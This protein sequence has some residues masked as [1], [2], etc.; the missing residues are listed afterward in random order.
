MGIRQMNHPE[1][2]FSSMNPERVAYFE[3]KLDGVTLDDIK[4]NDLDKHGISNRHGFLLDLMRGG[5]APIAEEY[6]YVRGRR[7]EAFNIKCENLDKNHSHF[8]FRRREAFTEATDY[9]KEDTGWTLEG[10]L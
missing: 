10:T 8:P 1:I 9:I 6:F 4:N 3:E 2:Q 7:Q 5:H